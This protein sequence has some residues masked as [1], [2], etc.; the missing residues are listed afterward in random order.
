MTSRPLYLLMRLTGLQESIG[1]HV[2]LY[3]DSVNITGADFNY[4][5]SGTNIQLSYGLVIALAG[6]FYANWTTSSGCAVQ[7]SDFWK[8]NQ[9]AAVESVVEM[10]GWLATNKWNYLPCILRYMKE[11]RKNVLDAVKNGMDPAQVRRA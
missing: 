5:V 11:Q 8:T 10:S 3:Y 6:D 9:S 4:S 1:D 2:T 7:I